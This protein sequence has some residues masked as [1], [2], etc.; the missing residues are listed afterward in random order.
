MVQNLRAYSLLHVAT[1]KWIMCLQ[2]NIERS[3]MSQRPSY[4]DNAMTRIMRKTFPGVAK[5]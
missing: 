3:S 1:I 2:E 4:N 5:N